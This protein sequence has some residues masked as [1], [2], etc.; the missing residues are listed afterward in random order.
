MVLYMYRPKLNEYTAT[1]E[2]LDH[3]SSEV[4][5]WIAAGKLQVS[6]DRDF[7]L[8]TPVEAHKYVVVV[9]GMCCRTLC[10]LTIWYTIPQVPGIRGITREGAVQNIVLTLKPHAH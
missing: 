5:D 9:V 8:E 4:F 6:V 3:R 10:I 2:E 7:P 1:R